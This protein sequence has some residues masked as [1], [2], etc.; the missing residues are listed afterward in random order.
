[1]KHAW[2]DRQ[3][4]YDGKQLC[5]HWAFE[6]TG[7]AED[8]IAS[9][10]GPADVPIS[11]MVDLE[12]VR[13]NAPIFSKSMLHFIVEHF[14]C[15]LTLAIARQRLLTAIIAQR[16]IRLGALGIE[17][18]GDDIFIGDKKL[19]VSIAT[20]SPVSTLIHFALNIS[21][22][23]TPVP[24]IGLSDIKI[25]PNKLAEDVMRDYCGEIESM[26]FARCKVRMV[27]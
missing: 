11:N 20:A 24:T 18:R 8:I 9:F 27:E 7:I 23:G 12:D 10:I 13:K 2:I 21:S 15:D 6:Q 25:N 4:K 16:L 17:R 3:I 22:D 14:D 1:M 19:S 26:K 5:S